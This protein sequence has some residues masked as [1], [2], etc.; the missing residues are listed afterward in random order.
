MDV[1]PTMVPR[2]SIRGRTQPTP[3]TGGDRDD[4]QVLLAEKLSEREGISIELAYSI[5]SRHGTAY[6]KEAGQ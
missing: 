5:I 1:T 4:E 3:Q 6:L 2:M